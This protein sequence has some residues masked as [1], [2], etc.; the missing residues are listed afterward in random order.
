MKTD[1]STGQ[2]G[3]RPRRVKRVVYTR[4]AIRA[5]VVEMAR[6]ISAA[7]GADE[8]VLMLGLLK[9]SFIFLAD[10][11]R[12]VQLPLQVDFLLA[13]SYGDSMKS[14]GEVRLLY[15]PKARL[16]GRSVIVVEDI[17]DSGTTLNRL[18]P[19]LEE[20][21]PRSL[22]VCALLRK[23]GAEVDRA[24][25]WIGFEAPQEFLVGYGLDYGESFRHLPFIGSI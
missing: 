8:E 12:E 14:S 18:M 10:L 9:G 17:I 4:E 5:R 7:Y 11:V 22:D 6:E 16:V 13:S 15:A 21:R 1:F 3:P 20:R 25:R 23:K 2:M 19:L 24:P